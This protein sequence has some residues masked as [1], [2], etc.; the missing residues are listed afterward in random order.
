LSARI[1]QIARVTMSMFSADPWGNSC[2]LTGLLENSAALRPSNAG[3][4]SI[5]GFVQEPKSRDE[6]A[7][8]AAGTADVL[9]EVATAMFVAA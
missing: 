3:P 4:N 1:L 8:V 2:L 6:T 5:V 7:S 9:V